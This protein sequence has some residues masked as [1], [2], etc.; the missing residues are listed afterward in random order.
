MAADGA[1]LVVG[2]DGA[3]GA[4]VAAR[5]EVAGHDVIRTDRKSVV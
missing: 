1:V 3:I 2:A 5:L 4:A